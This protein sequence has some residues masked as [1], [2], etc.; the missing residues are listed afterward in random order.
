M[1]GPGC[2]PGF[3]FWALRPVPVPDP[4][5]DPALFPRTLAS[6]Q[7]ELLQTLEQSGVSLTQSTLSRELKALG[8]VLNEATV[9]ARAMELSGKA[10]AAALTQQEK[11]AATMALIA[12]AAGVAV[13]DLERTQDSSANTARRVTAEFLNLRDGLAMAVMPAL[14]AVLSAVS[15][16]VSGNGL[17]A[18]I[19][20]LQQARAN[21]HALCT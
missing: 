3:R 18:I 14:N 21:G 10:N 2:S 16:M 17:P 11:A 5:P 12:Q 8:I 4:D 9:Q 6:N 1:P 20:E 7:N 13:G 19:A 15:D